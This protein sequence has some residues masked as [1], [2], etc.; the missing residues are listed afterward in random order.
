VHRARWHTRCLAEEPDQCAQPTRL[1]QFEIEANAFLRGMVR[2]I[3]GTLLLVGTGRLSESGFAELLS[4]R[5]ISRAG[6]PVSACGLCLW[7]VRYDD[8]GECSGR[9]GRNHL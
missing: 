1:L 3:A 7:C 5:E 8:E 6:A 4:S 2:R 9:D